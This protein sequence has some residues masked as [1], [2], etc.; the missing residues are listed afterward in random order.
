MPTSSV[1]DSTLPATP[2]THWDTAAPFDFVRPRGAVLW[3]RVL[4][5]GEARY[6]SAA[7]DNLSDSAPWW[8]TERVHLHARL[9]PKRDI[10]ELSALLAGRTP[11]GA[12]WS[13]T[14]LFA[15]RVLT[16]LDALGGSCRHPL[17]PL[18]DVERHFFRF[19]PSPGSPLD[20]LLRVSWRVA[21]G[22]AG[23]AVAKP[24]DAATGEGADAVAAAL[25]PVAPVPLWELGQWSGHPARPPEH[26]SLR[27]GLA[28]PLGRSDQ[29][30]RYF[31]RA[32]AGLNPMRRAASYALQ[33]FSSHRL[34]GRARLPDASTHIASLWVYQ[35]FACLALH[36]VTVALRLCAHVR[37]LCARLVAANEAIPYDPLAAANVRRSLVSRLAALEQLAMQPPLLFDNLFF[38]LREELALPPLLVFCADAR[39]APLWDAHAASAL[40]AV[41]GVRAGMRDG[42]DQAGP[43]PDLKHRAD[44]YDV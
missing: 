5:P 13:G 6:G 19:T 40:A 2:D 3:G 4:F 26:S 17:P 11:D 24:V 38:E 25:R 21:V 23:L 31:S 41:W 20:A 1:L 9:D 34:P 35:D 8:V 22:L 18:A 39:I 27:R 44:R 43:A 33:R 30:L 29:L 14:P 36:L 7:P 15:A 28:F 12:A 37:F 16:V 42:V 32:V 10:A